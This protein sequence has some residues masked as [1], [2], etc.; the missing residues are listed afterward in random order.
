VELC[1]AAGVEPGRAASL[2]LSQEPT[3]AVRRALTS[4]YNDQGILP[5][6]YGRGNCG[7]AIDML[8]KVNTR[9][10]WSAGIIF[11]GFVMG[12]QDEE[13]IVS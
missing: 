1:F 13:V 11:P 4:S 2:T 9:I 12:K 7:E 3:G 10:S 6:L 8:M 5:A